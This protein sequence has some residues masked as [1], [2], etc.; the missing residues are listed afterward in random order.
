MGCSTSSIPLPED[1]VASLVRKSPGLPGRV[2]NSLPKNCPQE[3]SNK[4]H[5]WDNTFGSTQ[6][7]PIRPD[8]VE[9]NRTCKSPNC[10]KTVPPESDICPGCLAPYAFKVLWAFFHSIFHASIIFDFFRYVKLSSVP[11]L[12]VVQHAWELWMIWVSTIYRFQLR[13]LH[14]KR[15]GRRS[16]RV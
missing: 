15:N 6:P 5:R 3:G 14:G 13:Q 8:L 9:D 1:R 10:S 16:Q 4:L 12:S 7:H 2:D 11:A